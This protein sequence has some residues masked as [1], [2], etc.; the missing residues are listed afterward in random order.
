MVTG[1]VMRDEE[2]LVAQLLRDGAGVNVAS[3]YTVRGL[4]DQEYL[5]ALA[6]LDSVMDTK[7]PSDVRLLTKLC[8]SDPRAKTY[9]RR[10]FHWWMEA[11]GDTAPPNLEY[12]VRRTYT[13][14]QCHWTWETISELPTGRWPFTLVPR[15]WKDC[16]PR[17]EVRVRLLE[18]L[19]SGERGI[20][21]LIEISKI[22]DRALREWFLGC[23]D[24]PRD[25]VR[26]I[27]RWPEAN[28]LPLRRRVWRRVPEEGY[29]EVFSA[30]LDEASAGQE[31]VSLSRELGWPQVGSAGELDDV[32]HRRFVVVWTDGATTCD[33]MVV[34]MR[35]EETTLL[36]RWLE[37]RS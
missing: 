11:E 37:R 28:A 1:A 21:K 35:D 34:A 33:R 12:A 9:Y 6:F 5:K 23:G 25:L 2:I 32:P 22:D 18:M 4:P 24:L 26:R 14:S 7:I 20:W 17:D 30:D 31:I 27:K 36:V 8:F 13:K 15:M 3:V 10:I 29:Q 16:I 19:N